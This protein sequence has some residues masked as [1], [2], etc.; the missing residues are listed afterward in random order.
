VASDPEALAQIARLLSNNAL[1]T[2]TSAEVRAAV[3]ADIERL[4]DGLVAEAAASDDVS[5]RD[6]ALAFLE[7]RM[8]FLKGL[9]DDAAGTRLWQAVQAKIDAW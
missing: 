7:M 6:S 1:R 3:S 2:S 8:R 9:L 4:A 5:D